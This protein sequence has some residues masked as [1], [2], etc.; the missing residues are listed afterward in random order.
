MLRAGGL[1]SLALNRLDQAEQWLVPTIASHNTERLHCFYA[2]SISYAAQGRLASPAP[3]FVR[4]SD[5]DEQFASALIALAYSSAA[6]FV[7]DLGSASQYAETAAS[8]FER[9]GAQKYS[10][11]ARTTAA[12]IQAWHDLDKGLTPD[13]TKLDADLAAGLL[14]LTGATDD[15]DVFLRWFGQCR[16]S[17]AAG[18]LQF[19]RFAK[20][21]RPLP[22]IFELPRVLRM[23]ETTGLEWTTPT[24][25]TLE[26]AEQILRRQMDATHTGRIPLLSD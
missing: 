22:S 19:R 20:P 10:R 1:Y 6:W 9:I 17:V 21:P 25:A 23:N 24:A 15:V 13:F 11:R 18:L 26:Q 12:L 3:P 14:F 7:D 2:R 8:T 4:L 5:V 16:P